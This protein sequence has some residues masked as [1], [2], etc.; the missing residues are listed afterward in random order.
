MTT[1]LREQFDKVFAQLQD[2]GLLMA[3]DSRLPSV[4]HIVAGEK[5]SGSW[6]SH[7]RAQTIF[8]V[9]EMLV[10]HPDVLMMKLISGKVTFVHR[11]LWN[12]IY[13]IG[14]GREDWQLRSLSPNARALLKALDE[15]GTIQAHKMKQ[16]FGPR[17]GEVARELESQLLIH[18]EQIHTESGKHSKIIESWD[19]WAKRAGLRARATD[20][21]AARRFIEQLLTKLNTKYDGL[22]R[23]PWPSTL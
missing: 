20:P 3:W 5:V 19:A 17:P 12:R 10:D 18:A 4:T 23:L 14:V 7:K 15:A 9:T 13:S 1:G 2:D 8:D 11:K 21:G 6:W 22:G 16:E